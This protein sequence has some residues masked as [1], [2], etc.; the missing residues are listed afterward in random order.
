MQ[1]VVDGTIVNY[2]IFGTGKKWLVFLHGWQENLTDWQSIAENFQ[3]RYKIL[4]FDFPGFGNSSKPKTDWD[5]YEY[6]KFTE[7]LLE[8]LEINRC[9]VLG[10]SFGGRVA[11]LLAARTKLIDRLILVDAAGMEMK[12]MRVKILRVLRPILKLIPK[13]IKKM[14][15]SDDY[16][17]AGDMRGIFL[18]VI[19]QPLRN[20][21]EKIS[22]PTLIVWGEKDT[23]LS[24]DEAKMLKKGIKNSILRIVWKGSHWPHK[25]QRVKLIQV[26]EEEGI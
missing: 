10:Y 18:K 25:Q 21:L 12:S 9:I 16:K 23:Q 19:N 15:I 26:L 2:V 6:S 24:L 4:I 17:Q 5:I 7:K 13:S 11:I 22:V 1:K 3:N 14:W 8:T 20:E